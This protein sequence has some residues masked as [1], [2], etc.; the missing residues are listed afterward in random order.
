MFHLTISKLSLPKG[1]LPQ[2]VR[3]ICAKFILRQCHKKSLFKTGFEGFPMSLLQPQ[4]IP[5]LTADSIVGLITDRM[6]AC[7]KKIH[8]APG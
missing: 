7:P 6:G 2:T 5:F 4:G 1:Q 3:I 8:P